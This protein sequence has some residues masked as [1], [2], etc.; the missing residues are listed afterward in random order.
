MD[1]GGSFELGSFRGSAWNIGSNYISV[2]GGY[3]YML[4]IEWKSLKHGTCTAVYL[5]ALSG[6]YLVGYEVS[7][8][9]VQGSAIYESIGE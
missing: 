1:G 2:H 9:L 3:R 4:D 8:F 6:L 5:N 7:C